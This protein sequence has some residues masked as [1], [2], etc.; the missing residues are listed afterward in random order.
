MVRDSPGELVELLR[1]HAANHQDEGYYYRV[2]ALHDLKD[3]VEATARFL[4]LNRTCFNG[5]YRVNQKGQFNVARGSYKNPIICDPD[6]IMAAAMTLR[7]AQ[8]KLADFGE[9]GL[10]EAGPKENRFV[11]CDPPHHG[12]YA[13]YTVHHFAEPDQTKLR[14]LITQWAGAGAKVMCSNSNTEFIRDTYRDP[15]FRINEV[16]APRNISADGRT[17]GSVTELLITTYEPVNTE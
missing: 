2:R 11:Y 5:L 8:I 12:T 3:P 17:R 4:Y 6:A 9:T 16:S 15:M 1:D 10:H 7:K 13:G 14:D